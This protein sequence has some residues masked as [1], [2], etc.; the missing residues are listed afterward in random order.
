MPPAG[1]AMSANGN[2]TREA[3]AS[4]RSGRGGSLSNGA[5]A[6]MLEGAAMRWIFVLYQEEGAFYEERVLSGTRS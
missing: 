6:L 5:A 2:R 3:P 1:E 4:R